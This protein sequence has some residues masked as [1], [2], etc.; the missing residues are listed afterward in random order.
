M[1]FL[2]LLFIVAF[3]LAW[4]KDALVHVVQLLFII[5]RAGLAL[6]LGLLLVPLTP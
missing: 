1:A 6:G 3:M 4:I 5:H 2:K